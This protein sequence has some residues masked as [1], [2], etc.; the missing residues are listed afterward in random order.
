MHGQV[1]SADSS[2]LRV[3]EQTAQ[4]RPYFASAI[5]RGVSFDKLSYASFI[6]LQDK[7]HANLARKR[8]LVAVGTHDLDK[9]A[10]GDITYEVRGRC[11]TRVGGRS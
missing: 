1:R 7:L 2:C 8:T 9:I 6:D 11:G 5:L 10:P 3:A 4:I